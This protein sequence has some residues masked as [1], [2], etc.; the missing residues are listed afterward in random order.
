MLPQLTKRKS[1]TAS[2]AFALRSHQA[3]LFLLLLELKMFSLSFP[4]LGGHCLI[5]PTLSH[6]V[7]MSWSHHRSKTREGW[8]HN[9][10]QTH[11]AE[12]SPAATRGSP[13][14]STRQKT[15]IPQDRMQQMCANLSSYAKQ[16]RLLHPLLYWGTCPPLLHIWFL[17]QL[18]G[19]WCDA[20]IYHY[21][22]HNV[23]G[24]GRLWSSKND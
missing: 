11:I 13:I 21:A 22:S 16:L 9:Q 7:N 24:R 3:P 19:K 1:G 20:G 15:L 14:H 23:V 12:R 18:W 4:T 2:R 8:A 10:W 17:H 5:L 6:K